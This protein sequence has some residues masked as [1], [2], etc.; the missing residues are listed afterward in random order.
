MVLFVHELRG[1]LKFVL[2]FAHLVHLLLYQSLHFLSHSLLHLL[3][4]LL[5]G[6]FVLLK[7]LIQLNPLFLQGFL[8]RA[9][10]AFH[11]G[12]AVFVALQLCVHVFQVFL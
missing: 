5:Y 8:C 7:L 12:K 2:H 10:S 6:P 3:L 1:L 9:Y 11:I 4:F